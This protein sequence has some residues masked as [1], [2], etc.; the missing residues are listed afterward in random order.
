M[1]QIL[2]HPL[3]PNMSHKL[4]HS[5]PKRPWVK[6]SGVNTLWFKV[7]CHLT[8]EKMVWSQHWFV[9][10][11]AVLRGFE[12]SRLSTPMK[13]VSNSS[14][15]TFVPPSTA[16][17]AC[18]ADFIINLKTLP[19]CGTSGGFQFTLVGGYLLYLVLVNC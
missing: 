18:L 12:L 7:A 15:F 3:L 9:I 14:L 10:R 2:S 17:I 16:A 8:N 19:K 13:I 1:W 11:V 4:L 5:S 6:R